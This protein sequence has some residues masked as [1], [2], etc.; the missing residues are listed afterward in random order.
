MYRKTQLAS[1]KTSRS[2]MG[3]GAG[4]GAV[5]PDL[6]QFSMAATE[7]ANEL[8]EWAGKTDRTIG[9]IKKGKGVGAVVGVV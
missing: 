2:T 5:H 1:G 4:G 3:G 9:S 8:E 7:D 6:P